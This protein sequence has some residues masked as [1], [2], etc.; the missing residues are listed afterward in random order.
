[1][2]KTFFFDIHPPL[3]KQLLAFAGNNL[4]FFNPVHGY[5]F[6]GFSDDACYLV[7]NNAFLAM[8]LLNLH[9]FDKCNFKSYFLLILIAIYCINII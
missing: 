7:F 1:M 8:L 6:I 3:G 5:L 2:K 4:Y 9:L